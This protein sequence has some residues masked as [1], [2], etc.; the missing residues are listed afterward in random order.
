[1]S[2]PHPTISEWMHDHET[3]NY[4]AEL[5]DWTLVVS[6]TPNTK[7]TRGYFSWAAEKDEEK[8]EGDETF[9]EMELAMAA[10]EAFAR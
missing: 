4:T 3:G 8:A 1:M 6:W 9:E 5:N 7:T 10:A 2:G